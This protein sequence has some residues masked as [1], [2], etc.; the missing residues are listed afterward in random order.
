MTAQNIQTGIVPWLIFLFLLIIN[1]QA[2]F[3]YAHEL[4]QGSR[5]SFIFCCIV[6]DFSAAKVQFTLLCPAVKAFIRC[7]DTVHSTLCIRYLMTVQY[8][9]TAANLLYIVIVGFVHTNLDAGSIAEHPIPR[10]LI[11]ALY[12][13]QSAH[14]LRR[15]D[16]VSIRDIDINLITHTKCILRL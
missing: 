13:F 1:I 7:C 8:R 6:A 11:G 15:A 12:L 9:G 3:I 16:A 5:G 14:T 4:F 2:V 10:I